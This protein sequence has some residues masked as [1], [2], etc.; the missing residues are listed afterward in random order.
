MLASSLNQNAAQSILPRR[1]REEAAERAGTG[2]TRKR[3][4]SRKESVL[5]S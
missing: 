1:V 2:P 3:M 4:V 5:P